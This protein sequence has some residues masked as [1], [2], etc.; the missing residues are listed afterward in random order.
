MNAISVHIILKT[1]YFPFQDIW[2]YVVLI[3]Y[4][5]NENTE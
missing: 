4:K 5:I 2:F 3:E 1:L